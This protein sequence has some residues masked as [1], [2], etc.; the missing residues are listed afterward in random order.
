MKNN[1]NSEIKICP[2]EFVIYYDKPLGNRYCIYI[3]AV[4]KE[5]F[6]N[7]DTNE[8]MWHNI[9]IYKIAMEMKSHLIIHDGSKMAIVFDSD[10]FDFERIANHEE[11]NLFYNNMKKKGLDFSNI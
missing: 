4:K 3:E 1:N 10:L 11:Q 6:Y 9:F 5:K 7:K 2:G 8:W